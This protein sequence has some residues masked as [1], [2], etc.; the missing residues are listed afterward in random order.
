[1]RT[2]EQTW[3]QRLQTN[4]FE[5]K[6]EDTI[7]A[8]LMD[9]PDISYD[10][11]SELM[12]KLTLQ[13]I[14]HLRSYLANDSDVQNVI[15]YNRG[16]FAELIYSQMQKHKQIENV[17]YSVS[18]PRGFETLKNAYY[19]TSGDEEIRN[20]RDLV[21]DK[22]K[23]KSMVF[24]GFTKCLYRD[25][26]FDSDSERRFSIICENDP[27]VQKW[28]KPPMS[29]HHIR[30]YYGQSSTYYPDFV[31]ETKTHKFIVEIKKET[32]ISSQVVKDKANAVFTW[33]QHATDHESKNAGK[34]WGYLLIPHN[35]VNENMTVAGLASNF[36][37][38]S[39]ID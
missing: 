22:Q 29:Q 19:T 35:E 20:F 15:L 1:L 25:Q 16:R 37:L 39:L 18:V 2:G 5:E 24:G 33:C 6:L 28:F 17:S 26:K 9:F 38:N 10:D 36:R 4:Y 14:E 12:Y 21:Q 31:L 7:V 32:D 11:H 30:I 34:P 13:L 23:I 3:L 27:D 8:A